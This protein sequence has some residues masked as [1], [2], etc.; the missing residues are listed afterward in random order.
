MEDAQDP[1]GL[2]DDD[3]EDGAMFVPAA[4]GKYQAL[5]REFRELLYILVLAT[6]GAPPRGTE[7]ASLKY[8]NTQH[9]TRNI[10]ISGGQVMFVR[11]NGNFARTLLSTPPNSSAAC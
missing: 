7:M 8:M 6:G 10:F 1:H 11:H 5:D 2:I 3:G 9:G 4:V